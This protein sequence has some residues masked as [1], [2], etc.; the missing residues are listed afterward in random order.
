MSRRWFGSEGIRGVANRELTPELALA[1]GRAAAQELGGGGTR[2]RLLVGR[3]TRVSGPMLEAAVAAGVTAA[4]GDVDLAGVVPAP[5]VSRVVAGEVYD[6]GVVVSASDRPF[7]E[8]GITLLGTDGRRLAAELE[9]RVEERLASLLRSPAESWADA[10]DVS[11]EER[12]DVGQIRPAPAVGPRY[13][14]DLLAALSVDLSGLRVLL[15]CSHGATY[16]LAPLAF[17]AAGAAVE[18][19]GADPDGRNINAG[20]GSAH[21]E[22]LAAHALQGDFDLGLAFDGDGGRVLAVDATGRPVRAERVGAIV[23]GGQPAQTGRASSVHAAS[24]DDGIMI[25]LLLGHALRRSGRSLA[26][27]ARGPGTERTVR[28]TVSAEPGTK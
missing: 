4:G 15:D 1:V 16:R 27:L 28:L 11:G 10:G 2:P 25:G 17:R 24:S 12:P 18:T 19:V 3:D 5:G 26:E 14:E 6:G 7:D 23:A 13:V 20:C 22:F 8:N 21:P 9:V